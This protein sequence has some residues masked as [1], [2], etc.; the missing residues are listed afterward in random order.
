MAQACEEGDVSLEQHQ[1]GL[2]HCTAERPGQIDQLAGT[3]PGANGHRHY[4]ART[5]QPGA[6]DQDV[7]CRL[8]QSVEANGA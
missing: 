3:A 2:L 1:A 4:A 6:T 7:S 5:E 8:E